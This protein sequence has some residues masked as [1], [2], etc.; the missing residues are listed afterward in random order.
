MKSGYHKI[1]FRET[2]TEIY[3][4]KDGGPEKERDYEE[5]RTDHFRDAL[6]RV[7]TAH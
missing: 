2:E 1:S 4:P 3:I 7:R 5:K 6:R